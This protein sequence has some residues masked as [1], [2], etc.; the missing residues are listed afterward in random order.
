MAKGYDKFLKD[1]NPFSIGLPGTPMLFL[2]LLV[3][4]VVMGIASVA[5]INHNSINTS[6]YYIA[7][8]G[9]VTGILA[10]MLPT[11][12]TIIIVKAFKRYVDVK[13]IFFISIIG[14]I[15]YSIFVLLGSLVYILTNNYAVASVIILVGDASIFG[16]WFFANKVVLGQR[17][18][19]VFL[20]LVQPTLNIL[21]YVPSSRSIFS[22]STPFNILLL[23]LYSGIFIFLLISYAIIYVVDR[24]YKKSYGFHSFDAVSQMIQ[25]WLFDINIST[26]F[27]LN[28]G[29]FTDIRT[30]T[31]LFRNEKGAIK[32]IF[33][34][35]DIH[36]GPSGTLGGSNFPY[37]LE[38]HSETKYKAPTFIM[39][40]AVDMDNNP[41]SSSQFNAVRDSLDNGVRNCSPA[42]RKG[43][44]FSLLKSEHGNSKINAL[45]FGNVSLV[46]MTRAPK[47]TE[48]V[49]LESAVLF[50]ELLDAK[51]GTSIL[52]DAHNSRYETAPK[53]ELD[54]V[55]FNSPFAKEYVKAIKAIGSTAHKSKA[56]R[57]GIASKELYFRLGC[58]EDIAHGNLNIAVFKFNGY[59][60]MLMQ[61]NAN[62]VLPT[63]R[64]AL[65][66]HVK[67]KYKIDAE[68]YTT[69]THAVNSL[70]FNASNVL[71]RYT[72]Y[73]KLVGVFD[74]T[75][76]KA[77]S[78]VEQ[79]SVY[80][81]R[82]EIRKF[83]VWGQNAMENIIAIANSIFGITR[84]LV[85]IIVVIGFIIAAWVILII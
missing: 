47:V 46:T 65:I 76:E 6:F 59:S 30:D 84:L 41:I 67:E 13:Y 16:W 51:L 4:S 66:R 8:N 39:H 14:T 44:R 69:D 18:R 15:S 2:M 82:N 74:E 50:R 42:G 55:K 54:G 52:V 60:H 19:A 61:V 75:I 80:H 48:D 7:A 5:L 56:V 26:P 78:N 49:S 24:P 81:S 28:F 85:P 32:G 38:R 23:K 25:N 12:L 68:L 31:L 9:S 37:M 57:M 77:L 21:L 29:T 64:E 40:C 58:P 33:F 83:K 53:P 27:G 72:K 73:Q 34:A 62:N 3:M 43:F 71:G 63:L 20:A 17:K 36:Y 10:I 1:L 22:F 11:L 45:M 35:P 79:V 70:E